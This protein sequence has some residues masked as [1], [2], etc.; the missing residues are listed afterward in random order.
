M[1]NMEKITANDKGFVSSPVYHRKP[2][3]VV[4]ADITVEDVADVMDFKYLNCATKFEYDGEIYDNPKRATIVNSR[5]MLPVGNHTTK[6]G[7]NQ[8]QENMPEITEILLEE[9]YKVV[10]V[11]T[12]DAGAKVF[13]SFQAPEDFSFDLNGTEM[14][15][16][17]LNVGDSVDGSACFRVVNAGMRI[18]CWNGFKTDLIGVPAAIQIKHSKRGQLEVAQVA[19]KI[20]YA[21]E[22]Q[23][24][25]NEAI[26]QLIEASHT[27]AQFLE[28]VRHESVLGAQPT[29]DGNKKTRWTSKFD[30]MVA[31]YKDPNLDNIR[32]TKF[33]SIQAIQW[34][35]QHASNVRGSD[36]E[37]RHLDKLVFGADAVAENAARLIMA[38]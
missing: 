8:P 33:G 16:S 15:A 9:G 23:K 28:M 13:V 36:R 32:G 27:E 19:P 38:S 26:E 37:T 25:I 1:S 2:E 29:E 11:G 21:I 20:R 30:A 18:E 7:E 35:G 17:I 31:A 3:Y 24:T 34:V 6:F 10:S 14:V 22:Q 4:K 5:T 12:L